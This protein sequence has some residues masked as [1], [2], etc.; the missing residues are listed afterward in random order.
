M[1]NTKLQTAIDE[2]NAVKSFKGSAKENKLVNEVDSA[3]KTLSALT[4]PYYTGNK[5]VSRDDLEKISKAYSELFDA[6][7]YVITLEGELNN[8]GFGRASIEAI[9]TIRNIA[10]A[11]M[12]SIQENMMIDDKNKTLL[13]II[14]DG[15]SN[16]AEIAE[17]DNVRVQ[18]VGGNLSS[19]IPL[20][21]TTPDGKTEE[22]F[23][24]PDTK[25][26]TFE[27]E[28][29]KYLADT[30]NKYPE[31]D[32]P[33][34]S[35]VNSI[36]KKDY[37]EI[38]KFISN[39]S[40]SVSDLKNNEIR[41]ECINDTMALMDYLKR[42]LNIVPKNIKTQL[43][44]P[45]PKNNALREFFIDTVQKA[46]SS[47]INHRMN[48]DIAGIS[49]GSSI[50]K[51]NTAM[52]TVADYLGLGKLIAGS[53]SFKLE[54]NGKVIEGVVQQKAEG[55]DTTTICKGD[56]ILGIAEN[57]GNKAIDS[58]E[59]K[60]QLSDLMVIDF[61]CGNY[62]RHGQNM[63]YK[64]ERDENNRLKIVGITGI[65]N[66]LS[67]GSM[68]SVPEYKDN[69][70][71]SPEN[72]RV[73]RSTTA[74]KILG[75]SPEKLDLMLADLNLGNAEK[76]ACHQRLKLLQD[77]ITKDLEYQTQYPDVGIRN[78]HIRIISDAD[79]SK[80]S[81]S[82]LQRGF[83]EKI[84]PNYFDTVVKLQNSIKHSVEK[85][86]YDPPANKT[87]INY[88]NVNASRGTA[89]FSQQDPP[90]IDI[91]ETGKRVKNTIDNF[92]KMSSSLFGFN[93]GNN[94]WMSETVKK[95][96]TRFKEMKNK[97][98]PPSITGEDAAELEA[99][100]RQVKKA[101]ENYL[102]T[103][104]KNP[105]TPSGKDRKAFARYLSTLDIAHVKDDIIIERD[106]DRDR[107]IIRQGTMISVDD[108][109]NRIDT[110][111][112]KEDS[113]KKITNKRK[114]K[115]NEIKLDKNNEKNILNTP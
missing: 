28:M 109:N 99:L 13:S 107:D 86:R 5:I 58:P 32:S 101:G 6:C 97:N 15:R 20:R 39:S 46:S 3:L 64:T 2:L 60:R 26:E 103:H 42:F 21:L 94:Q 90:V 49:T 53:R 17:E 55:L 115:S 18:S 47:A 74:I 77:Q 16:S 108:L 110:S 19:R 112:K 89:N 29:A 102:K 67:F 35:I 75:L 73:M 88:L 70:F 37:T 7:A 87:N 9:K 66:D 56:E 4:T 76:D 27:T 51:R 98:T 14:S 41:N 83:D 62:D 65:D 54:T 84:T 24:T 111:S 78:G 105:W 63:L 69:K 30:K 91:E 45:D 95:L 113:K 10:M 100:F 59:L 11:D 57:E 48:I 50:A 12:R 79:F 31:Q 85:G 68:V 43:L 93:S 92:K 22:V 71:V 114:N 106:R 96:N 1:P 104:P 40:I 52:S 34:T 72:M 25:V 80:Y 8:S 38:F 44:N 36:V 82:E 23:F 81:I 33:Y 61:I